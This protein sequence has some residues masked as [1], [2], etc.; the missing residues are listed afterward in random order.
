MD[1][2]GQIRD[3][4]FDPVYDKESYEKAKIYLAFSPK[5]PK[6]KSYARLISK[7]IIEM[8]ASGDLQKILDKYGMRDWKEQLNS[9]AKDIGLK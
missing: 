4:G 5:N 3:A 8:R 6:S 2:L 7:G 1:I 9:M